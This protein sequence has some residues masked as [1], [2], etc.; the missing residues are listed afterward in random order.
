MRRKY[1]HDVKMAHADS[2]AAGP[3]ASSSPNPGDN[4]PSYVFGFFVFLIDS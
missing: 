3:A 1:A 4:P 2:R